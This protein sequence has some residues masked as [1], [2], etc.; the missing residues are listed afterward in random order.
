MAGEPWGTAPPSLL[1]WVSRSPYVVEVE[2]S[3]FWSLFGLSSCGY[4]GG[5]S[6]GER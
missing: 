1:L 3:D 4:W 6:S 2:Q 5:T